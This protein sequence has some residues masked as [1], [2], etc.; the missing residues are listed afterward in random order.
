MDEKEELVG[1]ILEIQHLRATNI[2]LELQ[3]RMQEREEQLRAG[4]RES[5]PIKIIEIAG[6]TLE[7]TLVKTDPFNNG[8]S[9]NDKKSQRNLVSKTKFTL[10]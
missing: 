8:N 3:K 1:T 10:K 7:Q 9:C 5:W 2:W 4:G 6:K